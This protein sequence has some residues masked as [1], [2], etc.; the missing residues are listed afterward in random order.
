VF[1]KVQEAYRTPNRQ[2]QKRKPSHHRIIKTLNAQNKERLLKAA[3]E[4][5]QV[6]YEGR[7]IRITPAE[8]PGQMFYKLKDYRC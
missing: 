8:E 6:T 5:D 7:S 2:D 4:E 3:R 1:I